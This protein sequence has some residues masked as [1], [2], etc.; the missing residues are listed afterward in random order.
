M[1]KT[2]HSVQGARVQ[3]LIRELRYH[4]PYGEAKKKKK[5]E[6]N[7][8]LRPLGPVTP[9]YHGTEGTFHY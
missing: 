1:V 5:E 6:R 9:L 7:K 4:M 8:D 3:S 2:L